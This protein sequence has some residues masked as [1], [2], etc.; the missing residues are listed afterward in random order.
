MREFPKTEDKPTKF[1][2]YHRIN[3]HLLNLFKLGHL[4]Y[5]HQRD[6]ND[7]FDC[8][9][10]LSDEYIQSILEKSMSQVFKDVGNKIPAFNKVNSSDI[11][12]LVKFFKTEE[13]LNFFNNFL[14]ETIGWSVCC[15]TDN[16]LNELMWAHYAD[17][18][19][20]VCLEFDLSKTPELHEKIFPVEYSDIF[21]VINSMEELPDAL[22]TKRKLWS[23]ENEWRMLSNVSGNKKFNKE[24]LTAI[25]FG[26]KVNEMK[27]DQIRK[28]IKESGYTKIEFKKV[29]IKLNGV[30]FQP[31][32]F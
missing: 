27:I 5:S 24:S 19:N 12:H 2:K 13:G 7:L 15:F 22:F 26:A 31:V 14:F 10:S 1:Y 17:N 28:I 25:C 16:P 4:W 3:E 30:N 6:L 9:F 20:G 21:P 23:Y 8:K 29:N 32:T 11:K 18:N